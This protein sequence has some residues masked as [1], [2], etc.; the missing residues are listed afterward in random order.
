L[1]TSGFVRALEGMTSLRLDEHVY[2]PMCVH[3]R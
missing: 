2:A 3:M 1:Q